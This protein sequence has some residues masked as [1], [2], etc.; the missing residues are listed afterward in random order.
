MGT[1]LCPPVAAVTI[2][3]TFAGKYCF[4]CPQDI[5]NKTRITLMFLCKPLT[6]LEK[7]MM[8][9]THEAL[10]LHVMAWVQVMVL[11]D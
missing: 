9:M 10:D 3:D 1:V 7:R 4:T 5:F 6:V 2:K 8:I 11:E